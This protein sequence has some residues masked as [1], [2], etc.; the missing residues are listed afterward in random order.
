MASRGLLGKFVFSLQTYIYINI[1]WLLQNGSISGK[2]VLQR[3]MGRTVGQVLCRIVYWTLLQDLD[4]SVPWGIEFAEPR[5]LTTEPRGGEATFTGNIRN[6]GFYRMLC[7]KLKHF[8]FW[9]LPWIPGC[10]C[11]EKKPPPETTQ[12][13]KIFHFFLT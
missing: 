11:D 4:N 3:S 5:S 12:F 2:D 8:K 6:C 1:I 7:R 13:L 9:S 10:N